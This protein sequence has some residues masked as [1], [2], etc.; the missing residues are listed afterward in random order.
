MNNVQFFHKRKFKDN[1]ILAK[2]GVTIAVDCSDIANIIKNH[3]PGDTVNILAGMSACS[4][5][6][7]YNRS[8]GRHISQGRLKP[9][10]FTLV[11]IVPSE[12]NDNYL[13]I[14]ESYTIVF[15][16]RVLR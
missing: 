16:F 2:G 11:D 9:R 8:I 14:L 5:K 3:R 12:H 1:E 4:D 7:A 13:V 10:Q 15:T 6:D